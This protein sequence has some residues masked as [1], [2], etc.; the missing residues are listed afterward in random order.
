MENEPKLLT[1]PE[2]PSP[3]GAPEQ[4]AEGPIPCETCANDDVTCHRERF[5]VDQTGERPGYFCEEH[6][7]KPE[8]APPAAPPA[9]TEAQPPEPPEPPAAAAK[10]APTPAAKKEPE[11]VLTI[12][13]KG[14]RIMLAVKST[15]CDPVY[16][17]MTGDLAAALAGVP[18]L[19]E[20]AEVQWK[21]AKHYPKAPLPP[22]PPPRAAKPA[23]PAAKSA[24]ASKPAPPPP[25]KLQ[26]RFF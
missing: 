15:D 22:P 3:P 7:A 5:H 13:M 9:E 16:D 11:V 2:S 6:K 18:G 10:P 1:S 8:P 14:N 23:T 21:I 24:T 4:L 25:P 20:K 12:I 17:T 26:P 19:M